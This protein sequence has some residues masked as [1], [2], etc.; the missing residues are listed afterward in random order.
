MQTKWSDI[1]H[2]SRKDRIP[3][4]DLLN[5]SR[6]QS[7]PLVGVVPH[8]PRSKKMELK[9]QHFL[10]LRRKRSNT[11]NEQ[12]RST[13]I[14]AVKNRSL[15]K[16]NPRLFYYLMRKSKTNIVLFATSTR[17]RK[18]FTDHENQNRNKLEY[19]QEEVTKKN[20]CSTNIDTCAG[21]VVPETDQ[22]TGHEER[23][24]AS[25]RSALHG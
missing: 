20:A 17:K 18:R 12:N 15:L 14:A 5:S 22:A 10:P 19:K 23:Y 6:S 8:P 4:E 1:K 2:P 13:K 3:T 25:C 9:C 24:C 7:C 16:R 11:C 21:S